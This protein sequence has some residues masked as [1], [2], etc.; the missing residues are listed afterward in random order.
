M[1]RLEKSPGEEPARV[2]TLEGQRGVAV[3]LRCGVL[4]SAF[5]TCSK[6]LLSEEALMVNLQTRTS[7]FSQLGVFTLSPGA[8][9][10]LEMVQVDELQRNVPTQ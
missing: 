7:D 5:V 1:Q 3:R 2:R 8:T 10:A 9:C 6:T 4:R